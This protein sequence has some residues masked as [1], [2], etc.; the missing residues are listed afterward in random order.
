MIKYFFYVIHYYFIFNLK[1]LKSYDNRSSVYQIVY[2]KM[3]AHN[4][5]YLVITN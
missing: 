5:V 4:I 2:L 1:L 3:C